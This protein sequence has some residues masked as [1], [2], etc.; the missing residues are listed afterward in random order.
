MSNKEQ[1][2]EIDELKLATRAACQLSSTERS[3]HVH[4][5]PWNEM[6][7]SFLELFFARYNCG[8]NYFLQHAILIQLWLELF[9]CNIQLSFE[10]FFATYNYGLNYFLQDTIVT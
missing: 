6:M 8:S 4:V 9:F 7:R 1:N 5:A 10:L 2:E 3:L